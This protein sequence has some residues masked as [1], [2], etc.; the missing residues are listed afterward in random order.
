MLLEGICMSKVKSTD[1][2][3]SQIFDRWHEVIKTLEYYVPDEMDYNRYIRMLEVQTVSGDPVI[4]TV[5]I[6]EEVD[7]KFYVENYKELLIDT[8]KRVVEINCNDIYFV[9]QSEMEKIYEE[10][11][12][13]DKE[14]SR[15]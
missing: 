15:I 12:E 9:T 14:W 13:I 3:F 7:E 5:I 2:H 4:L 8:I 10:C 1:N 11:D 6:P